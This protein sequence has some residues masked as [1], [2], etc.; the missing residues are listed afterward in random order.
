MKPLE[1]NVP[2]ARAL[3]GAAAFLA[4]ALSVVL[5]FT[6]DEPAGIF[7]YGIAVASLV[8]T[9]LGL[10]AWGMVNERRDRHDVEQGRE[11]F[12][13]RAATYEAAQSDQA[14]EAA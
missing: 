7:I 12:G 11:V 6:G 13:A 8:A 5:Y 14:R 9:A 10:L 4:F 1:V 3:I 2:T